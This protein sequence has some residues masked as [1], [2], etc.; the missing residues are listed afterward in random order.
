M[1]FGPTC[2]LAN[3]TIHADHILLVVVAT[4]PTAPGPGCATPATQ[5]RGRYVRTWADLPWGPLAVKIQLHVR[6]FAG[7][8]ATCPRRVFTERLPA[9]GTPYAR[10]TQRLTE[11][12]R[13]TGL[14]AGGAVSTTL[15]ARWVIVTSATTVLRVVRA[16]VL[17]ERPTPAVLGIDDW[18]LCKGSTSATLL[19][20]LEQRQPIEVLPDRSARVVATWLRQHPGVQIMAR[21]RSSAY[22]EGA[23]QGAPHAIQVADRFHLFQNWHELLSDL[24]NRHRRHLYTVATPLPSATAHVPPYVRPARPSEVAEGQR[25]RAARVQRDETIRALYA[26]GMCVNAI[27][28]TLHLHWKTVRK[29]AQADIF[30]A[31]PMGAPRRG[32]ILPPYAAYLAR[33]WQEGCHDGGRLWREIQAQGYPGS[34]TLVAQYVAQLRRTIRQQ[35]QC[36]RKQYVQGHGPAPLADRQPLSPHA[37]GALFLRR[38]VTCQSPHTD[39]IRDLCD[40]HPEIADAYT[41]TQRWATL[42]RERPGGDAF[43]SWLQDALASSLREV[44]QFAQKIRQDAAAVRAACSLPWSTGPVEGHINRVK[45]IKRSMYGRAK[46]D[47]LRQRILSTV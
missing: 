41:W 26:K 4:Q 24:L 22:A 38:P 37:M 40:R 7:R 11:R 23:R 16:G 45:L 13:C 8:D 25:Q 30:P 12:I 19:V 34:R 15:L 42:L 36:A 18:A 31:K 35:E 43:D 1:P 5:I 33:R 27:A 39:L 6:K 2:R 17:P 14:V 29:Y 10:R 21:D 9:V 47:L 46:F 44:R 28:R 20:D 32:S 3:V